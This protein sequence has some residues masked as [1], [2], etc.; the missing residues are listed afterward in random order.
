MVKCFLKSGCLL[1]VVLMLFFTMLPSAHAVEETPIL[2]SERVEQLGDGL[3]LTISVY[4]FRTNARSSSFQKSGSKVYIARDPNGNPLWKYTLRGTFIV[5]QGVSAV[6][7]TAVGNHEI[8]NT[9]WYFNGASAST[10]GNQAIADAEFYKKI[11]GI[12]VETKSCHVVLACDVNGN[13]S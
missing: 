4:E 1:I 2:I 6:C 11:L 13:L 12:K 3:Y 5:N 9:N 10:S 7:T 8:C